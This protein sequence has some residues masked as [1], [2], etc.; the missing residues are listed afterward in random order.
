M[1]GTGSSGRG[2]VRCLHLFQFCGRFLKL[3][4]ESVRLGTPDELLGYKFVQDAVEELEA[5]FSGEARP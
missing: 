4:S 5:E 2:G 3:A 1:G